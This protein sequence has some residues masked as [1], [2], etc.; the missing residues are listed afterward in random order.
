MKELQ[1]KNKDLREAMLRCNIYDSIALPERGLHELPDACGEAITD[2]TDKVI[3]K[4]SVKHLY[5]HNYNAITALQL[6]ARRL[7]LKG[8]SAYVTEMTW[9]FFDRVDWD[10]VRH[11]QVL[12]LQRFTGEPRMQTAGPADRHFDVDVEG[13]IM[14]LIMRNKPLVVCGHGNLNAGKDWWSYSVTKALTDRSV[15][16]DC[17]G[18][19]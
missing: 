1:G 2:W 12:C 4:E 10:K 6:T 5:L 13:D 11:T 7:L 19:E 9:L 16:V 17:G 14:Q 15:S 8:V 18:F 3:R